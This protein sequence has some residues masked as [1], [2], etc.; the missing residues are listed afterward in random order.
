[1]RIVGHLPLYPL[2]PGHPHPGPGLVGAWLT[3]HEF[4]R[5]LV[6]E[7]HQVDVVTYM[8]AS[9]PVYVIDGVTVHPKGSRLAADLVVGHAG[10]KGNHAK[11]A[12]TTR[13]VTFA[14]GRIDPG[15]IAGSS[16]VVFNSD[17]LSDTTEWRGRKIVCSPPVDP[18]RY[19]TRPGSKV[20]LVNLSDLKGG[21]L[22][23]TLARR[24][25]DLRFLGVRG[26]YG[27]QIARRADN[28]DIIQPTADMRSVY[29]QTRIL[30]MPSIR[31]SWGRVALEA[32][33]SGIPT[34]ASPCPGIIEAMSDAATY[35]DRRDIAGW[36][37]E[38]E[39][40]SDPAEWATASLRALERST[41]HDPAAQLSK[42]ADAVA[43]MAPVAA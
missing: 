34:I 12:G 13:R 26:G 2:P 10:D 35:V 22:F 11:L 5:H 18:D 19:R 6:T 1:M 9:H 27:Q 32:A 40:L 21:Y 14:H 8:T 4:L 28:V 25:P 33:A 38:I 15:H 39:R 30:V 17:G 23:F 3:T 43:A 20:T 7:G 37:A 31:E 42:F 16:L 29:S 24:L 36:V 41:F